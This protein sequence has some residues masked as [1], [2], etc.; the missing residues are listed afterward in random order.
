MFCKPNDLSDQENT[1]K[2]K[3]L[4]KFGFTE[5]KI[6]TTETNCENQ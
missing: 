1:K 6:Q 4:T 2:K 3:K 5:F